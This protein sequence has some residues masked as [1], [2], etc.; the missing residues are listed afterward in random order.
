MEGPRGVGPWNVWQWAAVWVAM[1]IVLG[2]YLAIVYAM[3]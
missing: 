2:G 1:A 3:K